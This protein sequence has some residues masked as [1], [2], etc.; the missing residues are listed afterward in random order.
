[1][2]RLPS[3]GGVTVIDANPALAKPSNPIGNIACRLTCAATSA[4][5]DAAQIYRARC[6]GRG[7]ET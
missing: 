3:S 6:T 2:V 5:H 7:L 4:L 1:M